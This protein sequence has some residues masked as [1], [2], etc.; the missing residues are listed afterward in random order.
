VV[1]AVGADVTGF[2][3]GDEVFYAGAIDRPGTN[4]EYHLVDERI[5]GHKPQSLDWAQAAALPL[6][7]VTAW[8]TLFDRLDVRK[9]VPGAAN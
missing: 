8:E 7:S 6:T 3:V 2:K 5:V 9:P 1:V 4:S